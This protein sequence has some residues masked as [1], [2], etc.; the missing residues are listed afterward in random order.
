M[1]ARDQS[2]RPVHFEQERSAFSISISRLSGS[3]VS[4]LSIITLWSG[5]SI[6]N[7]GFR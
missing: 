1:I 7:I 6:R 4:K 5:A 3:G 2:I